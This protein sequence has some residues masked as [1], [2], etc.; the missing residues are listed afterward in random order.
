M[1]RYSD[2][3]WNAGRM[4]DNDGREHAEDGLDDAAEYLLAEARKIVPYEEGPLSESGKASRDG[5][6]ASV[7][8]DKPYA[9]IQHEDLD[10][11]HAPGRTAKYVETP[12]NAGQDVMVRLIAARIAAWMDH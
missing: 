2:L 3:S 11:R 5:L 1:G 8:F 7:S 4:W 10:F 9:V 12:L 6:T